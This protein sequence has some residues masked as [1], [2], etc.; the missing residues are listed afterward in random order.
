SDVRGEL[1]RLVGE[2]PGAKH[3][4]DSLELWTQGMYGRLFNRPG[5][6]DIRKRLVVFDL[7]GLENHPDL[8]SV[9]FFVIRS[10]IWGKLLDRSLKKIIVVDEGWKFFNDDIGAQLIEN[11]YRTARKFNGAVLSIS[12]SPKDFLDTKAANAI[13]TNS[14]IKY[15]LKL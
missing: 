9:Y 2:Y 6:L 14:Y 10:I 15:V 5:S 3:F 1:A 11:L 7:Q 12:Q 4:A 8:Q 13:I